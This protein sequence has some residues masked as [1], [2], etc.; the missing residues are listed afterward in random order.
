MNM[1]Y[2][3]HI[4]YVGVVNIMKKKHRVLGRPRK[5]EGAI[6]TK[7]LILHT[8]TAMFLERGFPLVSM[9]DVAEE[10]NIT[11]ATVYYYYKTK[12]DLFT[13]AMV[14]LMSR[15]REKS[16]VIL[17]TN[18]PLKEQLFQFA[19]AHLQATVDIDINTFMREAKM[20][21]SDEQMEEMERAEQALYDEL[22]TALVR[23]MEKGEIRD[24]NPKLA[25]LI[26]VNLLT[27][28]NSMDEDFYRSFR[29][30]DDL[31]QEIVEFYWSGIAWN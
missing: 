25:T 9:E 23:A 30:V 29:S 3:L 19:K 28:K 26:F 1:L 22:E 13:D 24:S 17:A 6:S 27:V 16:A 2:Y 21:L 4:N 7:E 14:Q 31:A 20:A 10:C 15:I 18:V 8:A 12:T 5:E 11:K